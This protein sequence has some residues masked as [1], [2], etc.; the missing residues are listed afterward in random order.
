MTS[1]NRW[2]V[3]SVA[4]DAIFLLTMAMQ[5]QGI[6][7]LLKSWRNIEN[8]EHPSA[9]FAIALEYFPLDGNASISENCIGIS[10]EKLLV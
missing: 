10:G 7:H 4:T 2:S 1:N 6:Q 8:S 3:F 9:N 5:F